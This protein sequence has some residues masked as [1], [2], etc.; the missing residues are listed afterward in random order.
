MTQKVDVRHRTKRRPSALDSGM[1]WLP[2]M[3]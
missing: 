1:F 2:S 3:V